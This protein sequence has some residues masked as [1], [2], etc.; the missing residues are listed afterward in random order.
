M[1]VAFSLTNRS[2]FWVMLSENWRVT[3]SMPGPN[4]S[5]D[6]VMLMNCPCVAVCQ[7]LRSELYSTVMVVLYHFHS[8]SGLIVG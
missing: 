4:A 2:L 5:L 1:T 7:V 6:S 8:Y 3:L